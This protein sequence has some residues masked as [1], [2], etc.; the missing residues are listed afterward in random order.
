MILRPLLA[1]LVLL[2]AAGSLAACGKKARLD[3]PDGEKST[4]PKVYPRE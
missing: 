3:P 4:Y 1:A 2:I